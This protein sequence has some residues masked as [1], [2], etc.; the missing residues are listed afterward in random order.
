[1]QVEALKPPPPHTPP[2]LRRGNPDTIHRDGMGWSKNERD[3]LKASISIIRFVATDLNHATIEPNDRGCLCRDTR[4]CVPTG[5]PAI[6]FLYFSKLCVF[7][8]YQKGFVEC[9]ES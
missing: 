8:L 7:F 4:L 9:N 6:I 3:Q 5:M 2:H 1:M